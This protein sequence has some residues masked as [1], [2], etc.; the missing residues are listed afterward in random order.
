MKNAS[1][2]IDKSASLPWRDIWFLR[3][4]N[5]MLFQTFYPN[6][7]VIITKEEDEQKGWSATEDEK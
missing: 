7:I 1:S 2:R 5:K 4:S 6:I 3:E